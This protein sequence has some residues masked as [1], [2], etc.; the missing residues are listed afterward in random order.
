MLEIKRGFGRVSNL[1]A[2]RLELGDLLCI[3]QWRLVEWLRHV[4]KK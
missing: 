1:H 3:S 2:A 4:S